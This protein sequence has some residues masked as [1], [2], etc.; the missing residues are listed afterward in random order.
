MNNE[1]DNKDKD[2]IKPPS[3]QSD[4]GQQDNDKQAQDAKQQQE[5]PLDSGK[6]AAQR[7]PPSK[8]A[9]VWLIIF[10]LIS[11]FFCSQVFPESEYA[12]LRPDHF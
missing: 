7:R 1:K 8:A 2:N 11:L 12:G 10:A 5:N 4:S 6:A 3:P 9:F